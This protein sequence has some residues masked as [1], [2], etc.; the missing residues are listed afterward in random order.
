MKMKRE[1]DATP[2]T[3]QTPLTPASDIDFIT[4]PIKR[5]KSRRGLG[6]LMDQEQSGY[7]AKDFKSSQQSMSLSP[8]Y[9]YNDNSFSFIQSPEISHTYVDENFYG[10]FYPPKPLP[11]SPLQTRVLRNTQNLQT[12][13]KTNGYRTFELDGIKPLIG[14]D[15]DYSV[16]HHSIQNHITKMA[17]TDINIVVSSHLFPHLPD[18]LLEEDTSPPKKTSHSHHNLNNAL[19]APHDRPNHNPDDTQD[20]SVSDTLSDVVLS[21]P[22]IQT[23]YSFASKVTNIE[24]PT[25]NSLEVDDSEETW[26]MLIPKKRWL[27]EASKEGSIDSEEIEIISSH[28]QSSRQIQGS[29][30]E[31]MGAMALVQLG[32]PLQDPEE[33]VQ[34]LNLTTNRY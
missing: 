30:D 5:T 3:P 16:Y 17:S 19:S 13:V 23:A 34:P 18:Q 9:S 20:S 6:P 25:S 1:L 24:S 31:L 32:I 14:D 21:V 8:S 12:P 2:I 15:D 11:T 28:P 10:D 26:R 29:K 4:P 7:K 33:T 22:H 27:Q